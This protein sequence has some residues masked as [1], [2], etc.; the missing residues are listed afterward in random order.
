MIFLLIGLIL[1][2]LAVIFALQ[3]ITMIS[4]T[5]LAWQLEGS[6]A[7]ILLLAVTTGV[8]IGVMV[9]LPGAIRSWFHI[10]SLRKQNNKLNNSLNASIKENTLNQ[11]LGVNRETVVEKV[12]R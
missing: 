9:A 4:V 7:V 1:G 5:F 3:N 11:P 6:L 10:S 12:N 8:L 2:A